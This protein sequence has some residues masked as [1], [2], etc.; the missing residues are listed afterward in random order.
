MTPGCS[1]TI[2]ASLDF[3]TYSEAGFLC[4]G[5]RWRGVGTAG[6]G[7]IEEVGTFAYA[8]HPSTDVLC[9]AYDLHDGAGVRLWVPGCP[10]PVEL[11]RADLLISA[12]N[13]MFEW[14]IWN[15]VCVR[16]YGWPPLALDRM[17][18]TA[19]A[20]RRYALPGSLAEAAR[21]LGTAQKVEDG[22]R[23]IK[24]FSVPHAPLPM[25]PEAC[26]VHPESRPSDARDLYAYCIA[27]VI[28]EHAIACAI[29]P[30]PPDELRL[31]QLDQ[32]I[33]ARGVMI[34]RDAVTRMQARVD[35]ITGSLVPELQRI[36]G[37]AV[38]SGSEVA[39][40]IAFLRTRGVH[41][42]G[43]DEETVS[44]QLD[45]AILDPQARR[46]L[47]LRQALA[48]SSVKKLRAFRLRT[49]HD[50][51]LRG[52]YL[53]CGARTGRW[54]GGGA[55][56]QNLPR[57]GAPEA[58]ARAT[59]GTGTIDDV[60]GSIRRLLIAAPGCD[61]ICSDYSAIEAVVLAALAGE[62]W[63]LDVFRTHGKIYEQSVAMI[64]GIP[65]GEILDHKK[66]TGEHHP[67]RNSLGKIAELASGF[68][69]F[70]N[71][72]KRFGADDHFADD[73]AIRDAVL[74]WRAASPAIV[75]FWGGQW[76]EVGP[77]VYVPEL[78]GLEGA[79][80]RAIQNPG[81][82][83]ACRAIAYALNPETGV[84]HCRLP[85][86]RDLYYHEARL[87][88]DVHMYSKK[89]IMKILFTGVDP[90]TGKPTVEATH[91]GKLAENVVQSASRDIFA[92]ALPRLTD[93]GYPVV[94][95]THDEAVAEV[96]EGFGSVEEFERLMTTRPA[97]AH[98]W[99]IRAAGGWRGKR[100]QK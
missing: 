44:G 63:R 86:G 95:H 56:L 76:R 67:L 46:V 29:P 7:G 89:P 69:G 52:A 33:N 87:V 18:D 34:D 39:K 24:L 73:R 55:Q 42:S 15:N 93:A 36:T 66:R 54:T 80:V 31:W 59:D 10:P 5:K 11:F 12:W 28:A 71:A 94:V 84:L 21:M 8:E 70:V 60:S 72:W 78:Y 68:G 83:C 62:E 48:L 35:V 19:A 3:E 75:E 90:K 45:R 88:D 91:G 96:P 9:A 99:P 82:W 22:K 6:K 77:R 27:D 98:D 4:D 40:M 25:Y 65:L 32:Q 47:E 17:R 43:L 26:R 97:W 79:A 85:S 30:M 58:L 74:K 64:T 92:A 16:R 49:S 2:P 23:L 61:L 100:Y 13:S 14:A 41:V 50:G 20:A 57:I 37:G 1:P 81:E 51:R 53:Y 38:N